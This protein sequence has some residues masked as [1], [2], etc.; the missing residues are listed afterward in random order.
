MKLHCILSEAAT[1]DIALFT[2][3]RKAEPAVVTPG[4]VT[5]MCVIKIAN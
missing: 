1:G 2:V 4:V 3:V 5:F